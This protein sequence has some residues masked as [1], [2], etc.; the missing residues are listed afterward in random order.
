MDIPVFHD[1]QHGTAVI[2]A[3]GLINAL[4]LSGKRIEVARIALNG[5]GASRIGRPEPVKAMVTMPE[6][7]KSMG[8]RP[9]NC[10][11]ADTKGVIYQGRTEGMNQWKSAHAVVTEAR[12][13]EQALV[14]ADVF[15]GVSAK[16]AVTAAMVETMAPNPVIFAMA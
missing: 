15:L 6:L 2:C 1:D 14:G 4:Q 12:T 5:A 13:L 7:V 11:M 3:A 9:E 10:I 16:G 8:A